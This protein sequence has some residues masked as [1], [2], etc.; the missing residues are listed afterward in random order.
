MSLL[1][2]LIK[3]YVV[4]V[5]LVHSSSQRTDKLSTLSFLDLTHTACKFRWTNPS[6]TTSIFRVVYKKNTSPTWVA[7]PD[8][9]VGGNATKTY[10]LTGWIPGATYQVYLDRKENG[11]RVRQS[12]SSTYWINVTTKPIEINTS[13]S[14]SA[15]VLTWNKTYTATYQIKIYDTAGSN[16]VPIQTLEQASVTLSGST[17][18]LV[19]KSLVKNKTYRAVFNANEVYNTTGSKRIT[20]VG[21]I[22]FDTSSMVN[23]QVT[24]VKASSVLVSWDGTVAGND[25]SDGLAEFRVQYYSYAERSW[26]EISS[27]LPDT[28]KTRV[29]TGMKPGGDFLFRLYRLG[30]DGAAIYQSGKRLNTLTTTL[31]L[32]SATSSTRAVVKW[33]SMYSGA[34]YIVKYRASGVSEMTFGGSGT[35]ALLA[36][37]I[38]LVPNKTYT[39]DLYVVENNENHLVSSLDTDTHIYAPYSVK[40]VGH[41]NILME[42]ENPADENA[43]FYFRSNIKGGHGGFALNNLQTS[44]RYVDNLSPGV[45]YQVHLNRYEHGA[46]IAQK[47]GTGLA[48]LTRTTVGVPAVSTSTGSSTVM[49]KWNQGYANANYE[50]EVFSGSVGGGGSSEILYQDAQISGSGSLA[51]TERSVI[52]ASLTKGSTFHYVLKV[53]ELNRSGANILTELTK[54]DFTTSVGATLVTGD[55]FA[56]YIDLSWV[57]GEVL[58]G[59]GVAEFKLRHAEW[60]GGSYTD[61]TDWLSH[62][63]TTTQRVSGLKPGQEYRF[64]LLRKG[65][66]GVGKT[67]AIVNIT[68]K[69][70]TLQAENMTSSTMFV[71]WAEPYPGATYKLTYSEQNGTPVTFGG[72]SIS[73]TEAVLTGLKPDTDYTLVLYVV[74]DGS[75][76]GIAMSA[77]GSG[78]GRAMTTNNTKAFMGLLSVVALVLAMLVI[79]MR[80]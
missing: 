80:K 66:D 67:H 25:E 36:K 68:T 14:S 37:L 79:R 15:A 69:G 3:P 9:S 8:I 21:E 35:T 27:W 51:G 10:S 57:P 71:R 56:S 73:Q 28:T 1:N 13:T 20:E 76:V 64:A 6:S 42:L 24:S 70:S 34:K 54:S 72:G 38:N 61:T 45:S 7:S 47:T 32:E 46:W 62:T 17:Y 26:K 4:P 43:S 50:I 40:N 65:L 19:V 11:S 22:E 41:T 12:L 33:G 44:T 49:L 58:E 77:L 16:T 74:E 53:K 59:D 48:H 23:V 30:V 29:F 31:E 52:V 5:P 18:S 60:P 55:I 75:P 78:S 39:I 2:K 63:V